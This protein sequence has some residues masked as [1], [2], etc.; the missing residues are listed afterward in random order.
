MLRALT[1]LLGFLLC[2]RALATPAFSPQRALSQLPAGHDAALLIADPA[3]GEILYSQRATQLQ[4]PASTQKMLTALAAKLYLKDDFRFT[5]DL[6][7]RGDDIILRFSG[8]PLLSRTQLADLLRQLKKHHITRIEG[9]ILLNGAVFSGYE[10]APGWPWDILGVCYSA[11]SSSISLEHNCVQGALYSNRAPGELTRVNV[12]RHQPI[13]V[14]SDARIVSQTEQESSY[15]DLTLTTAPGNHYQLSGCLPE[16]KKPLPLNFAVQDTFGYSAAVIR[17]ELQRAG[18]DFR[19]QIRRD[20]QAR[21]ERLARHRSEP[22]ETLVDIM[23]KDSDN[24]IADN[25]LKTLGR[26]YFEQPGTF[27]NGVAAMKAI[28]AEKA[29][30]DL[31][32]AVLVDGSGLSRNNRLNAKLMM[33]VIAYIY[34][35]DKKLSLLQTLPVSG[36]SGTLKYRQSIRHQPLAGQIA[37]KSGS[38]YGTHNL[39]GIITTQSGKQLL[40]VQLITNY[41]PPE[42]E[43]AGVAPPIELFERQLYRNLYRQY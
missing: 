19:G 2:T 20:D 14:T 41:H 27:A 10:Q 22:L 8:D 28:L 26:V 13:T 12:P 23:V 17:D 11:P 37:A 33:K 9:N 34:Q 43:E 38:L 40:F 32:Q 5:T 16:R 15:C 4:A 3:T 31:S 39:T 25:L 21:G 6:E 30:I 1:L 35:H 42:Q 24:L 7:R 18:I 36:Q 29:D